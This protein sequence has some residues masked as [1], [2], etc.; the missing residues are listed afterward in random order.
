MANKRTNSLTALTAPVAADRIPVEDQSATAETKYVEIQNIP[1]NILGVPTGVVDFNAQSIAEANLIASVDI[2]GC[3]V[4]QGPVYDDGIKQTFNPNGT[5]PGINVGSQAGD[6]SSLAN[7]DMWYN[8]STDKLRARENGASVDV[9]G[10]SGSG[11]PPTVVQKSADQTVNNTT[12]LVNDTALLLALLA[13]NRYYFRLRIIFT[14]GSTP[15]LDMTF[16]GPSGAVGSWRRDTA[17]NTVSSFG[18]RG[19]IAGSNGVT[20]QGFAEGF[21]ETGVTAGNLQFQWAQ[22]TADATDTTIKDGSVLLV[23]DLGAVA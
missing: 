3:T 17:T 11:T 12:T 1:L 22:D 4:S 8:S 5:N 7:G 6:P 16:T 14:S 10:G 15:D 13:N 23:Y 19:A 2:Q 18:T 20:R 21:I 9:I